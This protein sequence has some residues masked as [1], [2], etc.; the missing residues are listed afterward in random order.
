MRLP[1]A[2]LW[3][4]YL[5]P[6]LHDNND[7]LEFPYALPLPVSFC[8]G[9]YLSVPELFLLIIS[10]NNINSCLYLIN[11]N[12][13]EIDLSSTTIGSRSKIYNAKR[14]TS[15]KRCTCSKENLGIIQ[16]TTGLDLRSK[17]KRIAP[18]VRLSP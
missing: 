3:P 12:S 11:K 13:H 15:K 9:L 14:C 5:L 6:D 10:N 1:H 2:P 8:T 17:F 18:C 7:M 16:D 4:R